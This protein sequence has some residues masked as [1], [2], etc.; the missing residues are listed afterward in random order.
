MPQDWSSYTSLTA[1]LPLPAWNIGVVSSNKH[2]E[3]MTMEYNR[4]LVNVKT[5]AYQP[6]VGNPDATIPL[7]E[8]DM[9]LY[10]PVLKV[11]EALLEDLSGAID[12][13]RRMSPEETLAAARCKFVLSKRTIL[14]S[15]LSLIPS[16]KLCIEIGP[17]NLNDKRLC[18]RSVA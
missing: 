12:L 1:E 16:S 18:E 17:A 6:I 7:K 15:C 3:T 9:L 11:K 14:R 4:F 8:N 13:T 10:V 2:H 5:G